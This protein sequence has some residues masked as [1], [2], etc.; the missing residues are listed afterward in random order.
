MNGRVVGI[1][2]GTSNSVVC[3]VIDREAVVIP[4]REGR[5][6]HPSVVS[7]LPDGRTIVGRAAKSRL[8]IDPMNTIYS[9]KRL[10]G[11]PFYAPE[12]KL[13]TERYAYQIERGDDENPKIVVRGRQYSIEEIQAIVLRHLKTV[14]EEYLGEPVTRAVI[15]VPANFNEAQRLSTKVA[16]ELAGLTVSRV[17]NE[18][19]AAALAYGYEQSKRERICVYDFGG[20]TFDVTILELRDNVFEVL[21]TAGDTF[22]GGDDFDYR[23][24]QMIVQAFKERFGFDLSTDPAAMQRLKAVSERTKIEVSEN[25]MSVAQVRQLIPGAAM[26]SDFEFQLD[27]RMIRQKCADLV[28]QTFLVCD[29]ALKLAQ[30]TSAEIDRLVLVGGTTKMPL[31]REMSKEYFFKE[32][33]DDINP[34]EVIA[35]GA[36]IYGFGL[37]EASAPVSAGGQGASGSHATALLIDVTPHSLGIETVGGFTDTIIRRNSALPTRNTRSFTTSRDNQDLVRIRIVEG[38][39]RQSSDCRRLG[40]LVLPDLRRAPRG[41]VTIEVSFEISADG[42]LH[43]TARDKES[44]RMQRTRLNV[45]GVLD[46]DNAAVVGTR[47]LPAAALD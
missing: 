15:T 17:L 5:K 6:V 41:Q 42:M 26:P 37:D 7:F 23:I 44:G 2:L 46:V 38:E 1:D 39:S 43:V 31:V 10:I 40:E 30:V 22:L 25:G 16:G 34:D 9:A 3:A 33:N 29:E 28:Q 12:I 47:D 21:S 20:G 18:P 32:P 35:V 24:S 13:A 36:A 14:A 27:D 11:R 19:T 4:D 45:A 8:P